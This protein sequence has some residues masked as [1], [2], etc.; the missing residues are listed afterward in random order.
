MASRKFYVVFKGYQPGIY[1]SW[2]EC[3]AQIDGFSG[4]AYKSF[5]SCEEATQAFRKVMD[6]EEMQFYTFLAKAK[7]QAVNY[8][9]FPEIIQDSI[10][11]DGACDKNPGGNVEYQGVNVRTG[12]RIF[13]FGPV[14]G[15]SNNI[16][17][18][19]G[20]VHA[21]ALLHQKGDRSTP[22][23]SDSLT[24]QAWVRN[25]RHK[26]TVKLP[27]DSKLAQLLAR[28]DYWL[29]THAPANPILKWKTEE[30]GEIPADFGRK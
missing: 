7:A 12:E 27:P 23:Y 6:V 14:P 24:A 9:A 18:Y 8:E 1:D 3:K 19:L 22:I 21:L 17:E 11:V 15:G 30:W 28:A 10:A 20:L 13:H 25:K 4:A 16:G 26:S 29:Q 5:P 2:D